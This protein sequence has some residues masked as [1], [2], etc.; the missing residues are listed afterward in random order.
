MLSMGFGFAEFRSAAC[1]EAACKRLQGSLLD[2][3]ALDVKPSDKRLSSAPGAGSKNGAA[4]PKS[5]AAVTNKLIVRNL[6]FQATKSELKSLFAAF[7]AVK[8]V[9]IPKKMGGVHRGFAF[10]D[11]STNQEAAAAMAAL[12]SAHLYGRHLVLEYAKDDDEDMDVLRKR[13]KVDEG[14]IQLE[15]KRRLIGDVT[16][17]EPGTGGVS[18]DDF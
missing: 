16:G 8:R 14:A 13:A 12:T 4:G 11:F 7:G 6:A 17:L 18:S 3:H 9:R 2:G 10:I 1:A 5:K 15:K